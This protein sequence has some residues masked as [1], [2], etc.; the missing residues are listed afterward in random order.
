GLI[1]D[2]A[3]VTELGTVLKDK[4]GE[5]TVGDCYARARRRIPNEIQHLLVEL[6]RE[7]IR[8]PLPNSGGKES[9]D[10]ALVI[11]RLKRSAPEFTFKK[12]Y[13]V[14]RRNVPPASRRALAFARLHALLGWGKNDRCCDR[15]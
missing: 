1:L 7:G 8:I 14:A 3:R 13:T 12:Y 4:G 10:R 2:L 9:K 6:R 11:D 15:D 5:L